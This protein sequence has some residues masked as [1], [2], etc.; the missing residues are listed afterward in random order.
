MFRPAWMAGSGS[1]VATAHSS[2]AS[3]R[4]DGQLSLD[5][6]RFSLNKKKM[7]DWIKER[8]EGDAESLLLHMN[9][10]EQI[11][12]SDE[13]PF[14]VI[15]PLVAVLTRQEVRESEKMHKVY[16]AILASKFLR[17]PRNLRAYTLKLLGLKSP[18]AD[19]VA[20]FNSVLALLEE[21]MD[22]CHMYRD[23]PL[24]ILV[25]EQCRAFP[26]YISIHI[27]KLNKMASDILPLFM[28]ILWYM[29]LIKSKYACT[30]FAGHAELKMGTK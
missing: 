25:P 4:D 17:S 18:S 5:E 23:L 10:L 22:R 26:S 9:F 28:H 11:L 7:L 12:N 13:M 1:T 2:S 30:I 6:E 14:T 27:G 16:K 19:E 15:Q 8:L 29:F 20:S 24:D 3:S 21:I